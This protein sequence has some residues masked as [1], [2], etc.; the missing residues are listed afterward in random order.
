MNI[1]QVF[2]DVNKFS[3][4]GRKLSGVDGIVIHYTANPMSTAH[5]NRDYFENLSKTEPS[6]PHG[7]QRFASAHFIVGING[8][9]LQCIPVDEMA[10]HV[11][12]N[13]YTELAINHLLGAPNTCT[14]GIECCHQNA[15]GKFTESTLNSCVELTKSL[16]KEFNL[17]TNDVY[18][19]YDITGK[20]CPLYFVEHEDEWKQFII[21]INNK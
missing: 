14:I 7:E 5:N 8:E 15:D 1:E 11:G 12:A 2:L 9:V 17:T 4:P 6:K 20:K 3:R 18:R 16:L 10:Y 13:T 21:K 19:H